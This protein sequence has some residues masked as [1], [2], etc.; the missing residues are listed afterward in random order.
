MADNATRGVHRVN[1]KTGVWDSI[2]PF[3]LL[4]KNE[5][6]SVYGI[7]ADAGNNLFFNDFAGESVGRIDAK[8]GQVT[9]V[10]TPTKDSRP[11]RGRLDDQGRLWFAEF[12]GNKAGVYDYTKNEVK[13]FAVPTAWSAPYDAVL[14]KTGMLWTAGME[15]DRIVRIDP[16]TG[17]ATE[18]PLPHQ[19]NVR[20][21]F[22][23][24][25]TDPVT[26]WVGNN[27]GAAII[28]LEVPK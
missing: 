24:N 12:Y 4:P 2:D 27:E 10:A 8:T 6:H 18:Y 14:D 13:E 26:F 21:I 11:R 16:K 17:E 23:D 28:K 22:V 20:R 9:M 3:A 5:Q 25:R 15:T 1:V 19:T 7:Y